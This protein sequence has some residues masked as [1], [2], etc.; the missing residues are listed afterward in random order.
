MNNIHNPYPPTSVK[1]SLAKSSDLSLKTL[2]DWFAQTRRRIG[3]TSLSKRYFKGNRQLTVDCASRIY[4]ADNGCAIYPSH[5]VQEFFNVRDRA[6]GL[7]SR[8]IA[9]SQ[10]IAE[11][12]FGSILGA[13]LGREDES[14][15]PV[16]E[17]ERYG[18]HIHSLDTN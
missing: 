14:S 6:R 16:T 15:N 11:F 17:E 10:H 12:N 1:R 2:S 9:Q 8:T 3:W 18:H 13:G 4:A 5:L 7:F